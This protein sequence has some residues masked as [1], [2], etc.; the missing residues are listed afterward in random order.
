MPGS[1]TLRHLALTLAALLGLAAPPPAAR[2]VNS[3]GSCPADGDPAHTVIGPIDPQALGDLW[4]AAPSGGAT[5]GIGGAGRGSTFVD[6]GALPEGDTPAGA[7]FTPDGARFLVAHRD[8][9]NVVVYDAA[10]RNVLASIPLSGSPNDIAMTADGSHAVTA[11]IFEDTASIIELALASELAVVPVGNQPGTARCAPISDLAVIGNTIDASYSVI[12]IA[13]LSEVRRIP[14]VGFVGFISINFEHG[15]IIAD[16]NAGEFATADQIVHAD[17]FADQIKIV[18]VVNGSVV[19]LPA[20]DSPRI[21][22]AALASGKAVVAHTGTAPLISVVDPLALAIVK[23]INVGATPSGPVAV[24]PGFT[25]AAVAVTNACRTVNLVTDVVSPDLATLSVNRLLTTG[26]GNFALA[27]GFRGSLIAYASDSIVK[28]LNNL[29]ST[30]IGAVSPSNPRAVMIAT[31]FGENMLVVNTNGAAGFIES[32][33]GSGPPPEGDKAR[34]VAVTP[35][36]SRAVIGNILSDNVTIVDLPGLAVE[37]HVPV[38]DRP[39]EVAVTPD[40]AR[41]VVANLDADFVSVVNLAARTV[42]N[43]TISTRGSEVEIAPNGQYAYVAVVLNDGVWRV[44]LSTLAV[45]GPRLTTGNMAGG[46]YAFSQSSGMSLSHDGETIVTC[47]SASNTITI[48]DTVSWNVVANVPVPG[49]PVRAVFSPDDARIYVSC[50]DDDRVRVVTNAGG[51][52]TVIASIL[53]G[54]Q[55]FQMVMDAGGSTLYVANFGAETIGV[56]DVPANSLAA[57]IPLPD[58]PMGLWLNAAGTDLFAA[59][60]T[61]SVSIGP[62]PAFSIGKSG[63]FSQIDTAT[64][65]I[66]DQ[67]VTGLPPAELAV[68]EAGGVAVVASPFGDGITVA[69]LGTVLAAGEPAGVPTAVLRI[70]EPAPNPAGEW[71]TLRYALAVPSPVVLTLHDVS[72]RSL[73][74]LFAGERPRGVHTFRWNRLA[75]DWGSLASGVYFVRAAAGGEVRATKLMVEP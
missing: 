58:N 31:T 52:S 51:G 41:A 72:G 48:I 74:T 34:T 55:P 36:G 3:L 63:Q 23:T 60:G 8:S 54:D 4:L 43:I 75:G 26:D 18:H 46:I 25:K 69:D 61:W 73:G 29:V 33:G 2:A 62:G 6:N 44:N 20:A 1:T 10:T 15:T 53:V 13:S 47:N 71:V 56:V 35:D 22:G 7:V 66:T 59:T 17:F 42:S 67:I 57:T 70:F 37:G 19:T 49:F 24:N 38:G 65:L 40:G 5:G 27:V 68:S 50:R 64:R 11:N 32:T 14:G 12:D 39:A 21:V 30:A 45:E 9:K 28:D 16:F